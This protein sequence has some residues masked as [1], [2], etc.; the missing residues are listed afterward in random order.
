MTRRKPHGVKPRAHCP[1]CGSEFTVL[2]FNQKVCSTSCRVR[3]WRS[4]KH[5]PVGTLDDL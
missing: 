1:I 2:R 3:K 4:A 5:P